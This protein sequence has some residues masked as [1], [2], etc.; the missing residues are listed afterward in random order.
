MAFRSLVCLFVL[1]CMLG[2]AGVAH[3]ESSPEDLF[4]EGREA[5]EHKDWKGARALLVQSWAQ[6]KSFDTAALLGQTELKLGRFRDAAEHLDYA[7]RNFPNQDPTPDAKKRIDDGLKSATAHVYAVSVDVSEPGAQVSVDGAAVGIAP[8]EGQVFVDPGQHT[9]SATLAGHDDA[10]QTVEAS[11]GQSGHVELTLAAATA[12][13]PAPA[14]PPPSSSNASADRGTAPA[15]SVTPVVIGGAV[16]AVGLATG[17][18]FTL[19][20]N[21]KASDRDALVNA[22]PSTS[23]CSGSAAKPASCDQ[24]SSLDDDRVRDRNFAYVGYGVA[25]AAA[26]G[27]ALYWFWPRSGATSTAVVPMIS[28]HGATVGVRGRF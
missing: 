10:K 23:A 21:G 11:A 27:T 16:F 19:A 28:P 8:I 20:S 7:L 9:F 12:S 25:G 26:I 18:G 14:N 22:L 2:L 13:A 15:R 6:K 5:L 3:A 24:I 1:S 4:R 17:I